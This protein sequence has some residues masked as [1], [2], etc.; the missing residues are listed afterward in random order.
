RE[1]EGR[2]SFPSEFSDFVIQIYFVLGH[3]DF[4]IYSGIGRPRVRQTAFTTASG[5]KV[6]K[7]N[8]T[9]SVI[10][11]RAVVQPRIFSHGLLVNSP[12][13]FFS[14]V[15]RISGQTAKPS[16]MLRTTCLA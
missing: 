3:S 5:M 1:I 13:F 12:S 6:S 15:K 9:L 16:C 14:L 2:C 4:V 7:S 10:I 11:M 8:F